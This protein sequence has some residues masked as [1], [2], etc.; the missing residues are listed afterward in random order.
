MG[1]SILNVKIIDF[2]AT[3]HPNAIV[4]IEYNTL[5]GTGTYATSTK[6]YTLS[7]DMILLSL[8]KPKF[9][10]NSGWGA[11]KSSY[12]ELRS[13]N[14]YQLD[15]DTLS[16]QIRT[17]GF[18]G[19]ANSNSDF[20]TDTDTD[21][22]IHSFSSVQF[23]PDEFYI[24]DEKSH[25]FIQK[26]GRIIS[27]QELMTSVYSDFADPEEGWFSKPSEFPKKNL[28]EALKEFY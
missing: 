21:T 23:L 11:F 22:K 8:D 25:Q 3:T 13:K 18:A 28:E 2:N 9:E 14:F 15:P 5:I 7:K 19:I 27:G 4:E 12:V 20:D 10:Y 24:W 17:K 1:L 16:Y 6:N 26:E